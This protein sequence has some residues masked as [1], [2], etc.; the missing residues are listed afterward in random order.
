MKYL[1]DIIPILYTTLSNPFGTA[2][3]PLLSAAIT[4]T[5]TIILN[6]HPR[7]WRWRGEVLGGLTA[8]WL[9]VVEER[10]GK[11]K[12]PAAELDRLARELQSAAFALKHALQNPVTAP[13]V[14]VDPDQLA[15]KEEV[16]SGFQ[17]LIDAD[18][19]LEG[20]FNAQCC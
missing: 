20:L 9:H 6:A 13:G 3:P 11:G 2:H 17:A 15:A 19:E 1:Q 18:A 5:K 16:Q 12:T 8:C 10:K 4:T 7:I 14:T